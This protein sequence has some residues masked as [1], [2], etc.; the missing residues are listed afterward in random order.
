MTYFGIIIHICIHTYIHSILAYIHTYRCICM[1]ACICMYV[2]VCIYMYACI[3]MYVYVCMYVCV[4]MYVY[5]YVYVCVCIHVYVCMHNILGGIVRG[6]NVLPKTGGGIVR[7]GIVRGGIVRGGIGPG[8]NVL[9]PLWTMF[10]LSCARVRAHTGRETS[11]HKKTR[12]A[13]KISFEKSF[14][15]IFYA[16]HPIYRRVLVN[17]ARKKFYAHTYFIKLEGTLIVDP[18]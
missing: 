5:M 13:Q 8:G 14:L 9:H 2:Y 18:G 3:C 11:A 1:Y 16:H 15:H 17:V 12:S 6:G 4:Y 10:P 7:G